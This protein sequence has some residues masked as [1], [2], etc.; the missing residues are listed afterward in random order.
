MG[1]KHKEA[2][3]KR[4]QVRRAEAEGNFWVQVGAKGMSGYMPAQRVKMDACQNKAV[5]NLHSK[6]L[7]VCSSLSPNFF[8]FM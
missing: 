5:P 6:I 2:E 7:V 8:I 3:V 4:A 1:V